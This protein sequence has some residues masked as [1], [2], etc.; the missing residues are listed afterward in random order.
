MYNYNIYIYIYTLNIASIPDILD[1][2]RTGISI[3]N[4]IPIPKLYCCY[5][6]NIIIPL[7]IIIQAQYS[8]MLKVCPT[9]FNRSMYMQ[10]LQMG[11]S[12][13]TEHQIYPVP[14]C[15]TLLGQEIDSEVPNLPRL[16]DL[17]NKLRQRLQ[18]VQG[19]SDLDN[20]KF[21]YILLSLYIYITHRYNLIVFQSL[22]FQSRCF[23]CFLYANLLKHTEGTQ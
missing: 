3:I 14:F 19:K 15:G 8:I 1:S 2:L 5:I 7:Y 18:C 9:V 17:T 22:S 11:Y 4:R 10:I 20:I 23:S 6:F 13:I 21:M 16:A 12:I